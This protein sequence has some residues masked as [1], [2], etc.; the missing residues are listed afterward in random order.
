MGLSP[1]PFFGKDSFKAYCLVAYYVMH[2]LVML[3]YIGK[4]GKVNYT[5]SL[6]LT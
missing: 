1:F 6:L 2:V 3:Q 5:V 4:K